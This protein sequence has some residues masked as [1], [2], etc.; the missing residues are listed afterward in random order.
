MKSF[1]MVFCFCIALIAGAA[2]AQID[3]GP[4]G[5]GLYADM[6]AMINRL[7]TEPGMVE[8]H[9]L[10][11]NLTEV[12]LA[13]WEVGLMYFG[14]IYFA[15]YSIPYN[16]VNVGTFPS[17]SVGLSEPIPQAPVI[18]LMTITIGVSE[19]EPVAI[20]LTPPALPVGGSMGNDLPAFI[21]GPEFELI[22]F[23]PSSGSIEAPVFMING[24]APVA[25]EP[26][27]MGSIKSLY[28]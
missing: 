6:D 24:E 21:T 20:Y 17:F 22:A 10:A 13:G 26:A 28:R 8:L 23:Y 9:L 25:T 15:G 4:N 18:H 16:H 1:A 12:N 2:S 27:T 19:V 14:P 3:T 7:D 5:L 11:T